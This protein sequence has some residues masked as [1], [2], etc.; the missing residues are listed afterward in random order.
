M[1]FFILVILLVL[2]A[3]IIGY[4]QSN[5]KY[6][7]GIN[8]YKELGWKGKVLSK[9]SD[10]LNHGYKT[11]LVREKHNIKKVYFI[12]DT[13]KVY[14]IINVGDSVEKAVDS[15]AVFVTAHNEQKR[16]ILKYICN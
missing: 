10:S 6:C 2:S 1:K 15:L 9:Y 5:G 7:G 11:L 3:F 4:L 13:S 16:Y 8:D 14:Q 12:T